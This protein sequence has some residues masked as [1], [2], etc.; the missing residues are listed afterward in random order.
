MARAIVGSAL[1]A[2]VLL[3]VVAM[4]Q[5]EERRPDPRAICAS[6]GRGPRADEEVLRRI[7]PAFLDFYRRGD[8]WK[9]FFHPEAT[10]TAVFVDQP[11]RHADV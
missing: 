2:S 6:R 5:R 10:S 3:A 8:D 9:A 11:A 7:Y 1:V 4:A